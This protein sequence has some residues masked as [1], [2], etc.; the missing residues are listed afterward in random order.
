M[1]TKTGEQKQTRRKRYTYRLKRP[2][3][4]NVFFSKLARYFTTEI[5][6]DYFQRL[7]ALGLLVY[8]L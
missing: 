3:T 7:T 4:K 6:Y 8:I 1:A 5:S 2:P